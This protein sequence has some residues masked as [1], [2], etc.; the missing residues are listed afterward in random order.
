[1]SNLRSRFEDIRERMVD[2]DCELVNRYI[3]GER[4]IKSLSTRRERV[5]ITAVLEI[6]IKDACGIHSDGISLGTINPAGYKREKKHR[7]RYWKKVHAG[8]ITDTRR[9][10]DKYR[11]TESD[12]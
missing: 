5:N 6:L 12:E 4:V 8:E 7:E 11:R 3:K 9:G 10:Y 1:M 2:N